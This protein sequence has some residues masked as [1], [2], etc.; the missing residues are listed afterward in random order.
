MIKVEKSIDLIPE[1]LTNASTRSKRTR[2]LNAKKWQSS[3]SYKSPYQSPTVRK[4]LK[5]IYNDKCAY[6]EQRIILP[7]KNQNKSAGND[8]TIEHYR[9]KTTYYWLAYSW[10][11][12]LPVCYDCNRHKE[13]DFDI[14]G[15]AITTIRANE[16]DKINELAAIYHSEEQPKFIHPELED[17]S[18]EFTFDKEGIIHSKDIRCQYVIEKCDLKRR[19]LNVK[20]KAIID[21]IKSTFKSIRTPEEMMI[22]IVRIKNDSEKRR[23]EFRALY[24]YILSDFNNI[25][26]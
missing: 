22:L 5:S 13:D 1:I 20:R 8:L 19:T 9:P 16:I 6:C 15:V 11:N 14:S 21:E 18:N 10:D 17:L 3:S 4:T 23:K 26:P 25:I 2:L 24:Q 12:L 7:K